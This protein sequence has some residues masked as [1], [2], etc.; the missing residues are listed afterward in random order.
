[1]NHMIEENYSERTK[2]V[3][4]FLV[5]LAFNRNHYNNGDFSDKLYK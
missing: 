3:K 2:E 4:K 1:M 5:Q